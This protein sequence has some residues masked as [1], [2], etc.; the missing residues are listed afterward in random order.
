MIHIFG[1]GTVNYVRSHF[2]LCAP[3]YGKTAR[4]LEALFLQQGIAPEDLKLELTRMADATSAM[5][6]NADVALRLEALLAAPSTKVI[7]FNVALCD[8]EGTI[9][10]VPSGKHAQRLSS[11]DG[12]ALLLL[13][14]A[15]KLLAKVKAVRPDITLVGFK[16]TAGDDIA[17]QYGK[18]ARQ[19]AE[20]GADWVFA[21]DTVTRKNL[22]VRNKHQG[23]AAAPT[24]LGRPDDREPCLRRLASAIAANYLSATP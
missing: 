22:L 20:T 8:Y 18:A 16:T 15:E 14:P 9:D 17:G 4:Q 21:N 3:A 11:R 19:V 7:I 5:E 6:T 13:R 1:G 10:G 23:P 12:S 2:A 24:I